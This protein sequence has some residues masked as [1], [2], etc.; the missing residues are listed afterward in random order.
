MFYLIDYSS[1]I[2]PAYML[3]AGLALVLLTLFAPQGL[4]GELRRR[5]LTW[6]P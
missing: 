5:Y 2:T 3:I 1:A 4:A 6:L